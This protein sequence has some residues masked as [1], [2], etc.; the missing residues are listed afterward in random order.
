M[1]TEICLDATI[2]IK[3]LFLC[4]GLFAFIVEILVKKQVSAEVIQT[5]KN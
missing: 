3:S 4:R 5:N 2:A 1:Y